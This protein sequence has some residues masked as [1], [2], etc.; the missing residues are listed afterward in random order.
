MH[1]LNFIELEMW[2]KWQTGRILQAR[3]GAGIH[4][5]WLGC[6]GKDKTWVLEGARWSK[7]HLENKT[8]RLHQ[9]GDSHAAM[10]SPSKRNQ[11][12]RHKESTGDSKPTRHR[13]QRAHV[14]GRW[15]FQHANMS[16]ND[17]LSWCGFTAKGY[18][19]RINEITTCCWVTI[20]AGHVDLK[21]PISFLWKDSM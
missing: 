9:M 10:G 11:H 13:K 1:L 19:G 8:C 5:D 4:H 12:G 6:E 7:V 15:E 2:V 17:F 18:I 21:G 20:S 14:V 3:G 16:R